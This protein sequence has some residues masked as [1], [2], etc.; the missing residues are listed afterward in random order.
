MSCVPLSSCL[1]LE[2]QCEGNP[3]PGGIRV[4][5]AVHYVN[6]CFHFSL[7]VYVF[8]CPHFMPAAR[9]VVFSL[10]DKTSSPKYLPSPDL[11]A[12]FISEKEGLSDC[13][14][15]GSLRQLIKDELK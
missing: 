13:R 9:M 8:L 14:V 2:M 3:V 11:S 7:P 4:N 5:A 1:I 10:C 15:I 12:S 6:I